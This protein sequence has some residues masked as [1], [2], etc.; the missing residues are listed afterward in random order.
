M[1]NRFEEIAN[2]ANARDKKHQKGSDR[3]GITE[4]GDFLP[5][6]PILQ[7]ADDMVVISDHLA[8]TTPDLQA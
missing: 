6:E 4:R 2:V 1:E 3:R 7:D 5:S 8:R